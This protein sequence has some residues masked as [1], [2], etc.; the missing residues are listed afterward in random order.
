MSKIHLIEKHNQP[1]I[2][3]GVLDSFKYY[4]IKISCPFRLIDDKGNLI[5][6]EER[7]NTTWRVKQNS[8]FSKKLND[9]LYITESFSKINIETIQKSIKQIK[10]TIIEV[11]GDVYF[12]DKHIHNNQKFILIAESK[13]IA[14]EYKK[15]LN[16]E[17][18][19]FTPKLVRRFE[20]ETYEIEVFDS[21]YKFNYQSK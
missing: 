10:T 1:Y 14:K 4:D 18:K 13:N 5:H 9:I 2:R 7:S 15:I 19:E 16:S 21:E 6:Q 17:L 3:I 12:K 11:G 20:N 8:F